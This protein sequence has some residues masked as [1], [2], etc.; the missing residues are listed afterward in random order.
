[1]AK[2]IIGTVEVKKGKKINIIKLLNSINADEG[3]LV[4]ISVEKVE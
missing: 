3:D 2:R 1:M 4:K